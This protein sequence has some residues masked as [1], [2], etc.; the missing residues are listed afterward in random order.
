MSRNPNHN[1][2]TSNP[3]FFP[4]SC[5][6]LSFLVPCPAPGPP[7]SCLYLRFL[8]KSP[9]FMPNTKKTP[10]SSCDLPSPFYPIDPTSTYNYN[11]VLNH[12]LESHRNIFQP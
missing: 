6:I 12:D 9:L 2:P 3:L 7:P 10:F 5:P 4:N 8:E 11:E 1:L